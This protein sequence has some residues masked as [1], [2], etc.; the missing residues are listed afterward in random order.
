MATPRRTLNLGRWQTNRDRLV[1][2]FLLGVALFMP[3]IIPLFDSSALVA[4]VP[5]LY[6]YLF[7]AWG[8]L[9]LI[10]AVVSARWD[11]GPSA[12]GKG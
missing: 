4:G 2:A 12:S 11:R 9:I 3:P 7:G 1:A 5:L 6:L 10:L 8:G